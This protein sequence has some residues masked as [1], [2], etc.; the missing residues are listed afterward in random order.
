[1]QHLQLSENWHRVKKK[2]V[3]KLCE[4]NPLHRGGTSAFHLLHTEVSAFVAALFL[5]PAAQGLQGES[6]FCQPDLTE[7]SIYI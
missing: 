4:E 6:M 2:W 5:S 3:T 7:H 1:M